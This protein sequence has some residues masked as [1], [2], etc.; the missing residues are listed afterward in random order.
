MASTRATSPTTS[1]E[2]VSFGL[3]EEARAS[4]KW[5]RRVYMGIIVRRDIKK[6]M[7]L[8]IIQ[9]SEGAIAPSLQK[10]PH[11]INFESL[12]NFQLHA[13]V[14]CQHIAIGFKEENV[15]TGW[16]WW[17]VGIFNCAPSSVLHFSY[18]YLR[19]FCLFF[20]CIFIKNMPTL[21]VH[22]VHFLC[23]HKAFFICIEILSNA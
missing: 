18:S 2:D 21:L 16:S 17:P 7:F 9:I 6:S 14:V 19:S 4:R 8:K 15:L 13:F 12:T 10:N 23:T 3:M 20:I 22:V 1:G 11:I 5:R